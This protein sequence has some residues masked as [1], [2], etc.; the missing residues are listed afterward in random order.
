MTIHYVKG[1][2]AQEL[3]YK[4][5]DSV[6]CDVA[7]AE[8][9]PLFPGDIIVYNTDI[10]FQFEEG[11]YAYVLSRSGLSAKGVIVLNSPGLIDTDYTGELKIILHNVSR[12]IVMITKGMRV[13]QIV[14]HDR[15]HPKSIQAKF[16][17][18]RKITKETDR[19]DG[20]LGSTGEK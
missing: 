13:A 11:Q 6:A 20:G 18:I 5:S 8:E 2:N 12:G 10:R 4:T 19:G 7:S 17:K 14:F 16:K 1:K 3:E 9:S 15:N